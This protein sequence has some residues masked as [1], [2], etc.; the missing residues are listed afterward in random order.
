VLALAGPVDPDGVGPVAQARLADPRAMISTPTLTLFAGGSSGEV[1]ALNATELRGVIGRYPNTNPTA[2]LARF[3]AS[4]FPAVGG[5]EYDATTSRILLTAGNTLYAVNPVNINDITTWTISPLTLPAGTAG[6]QDGLLSTSRFDSPTTMYLDPA[7]RQLYVADTG[8]QVIRKVD[9]TANPATVSTIAGTPRVRG[10][11][12]DNGPATS[13]LLDDPHAITKCPNGDLFIADTDN[14]RVRRV[15]GTTITT[16]LGDGTASSS[17]DGSPSRNYTIDTP[18]G[19]TCDSLN[20]VY[21]TSR[22]AVRVLAANNA[23][24]VDGSGGVQTIYG[25][26][27]RDTFPERSTSCLT[28]ITV[29]DPT[30]L[31][32]TDA[33]SGMLLE[34]HRAA[35]P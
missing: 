35:A 1:Q 12:G 9:L 16:V 27:P 11:S 4:T 32:L 3:R 10:F 28:A 33:C 15:T 8:N 13:A 2:N 20:N 18:L 25:R 34:L 22:V 30:T 24:Q 6:H 5:V 31:R 17:G 19:L 21:V 7:T 14:Q 23:G 29:S 26:A